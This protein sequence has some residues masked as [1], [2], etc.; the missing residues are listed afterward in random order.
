MALLERPKPRPQAV[1][2][3]LKELV[4]ERRLVPGDKLPSEWELVEI[5]G[6]GRSSVREGVQLLES[7]GIIEVVHGKGT[8]L[9]SALG[10]GLHRVI[11][12]AYP[13]N[14]RRRLAAELSEARVVVETAQV[15]L[16]AKRASDEEI[17]VLLRT[18]AAA[19]QLPPSPRK[20]RVIGQDYHHEI[21]RL[22]HNDTLLILSN[23]MRALDAG[24]HANERPPTWQHF[25]QALSRHAE[26]TEAI[27]QRDPDSA[28]EAMQ[29][30]LDENR[31]NIAAANDERARRRRRQRR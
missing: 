27:V 2:D 28:A 25:T 19:E 30:H 29:R 6:V 1:A 18:Q 4:T 12:W 11:E 7:L 5:L 23:A 8:F 24:L 17:E 31:R 16:A 13:G 20:A 9:A 3:A 10:G 22:A 15:R 21:G 14:A 26:I